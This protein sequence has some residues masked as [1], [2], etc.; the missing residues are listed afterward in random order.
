VVVRNLS[1]SRG[2]Y[3]RGWP[4]ERRLQE[5]TWEFDVR[6]LTRSPKMKMEQIDDLL[7]SDRAETTLPGQ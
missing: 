2:S 4:T 3:E 1:D 7:H 6:E 5:P